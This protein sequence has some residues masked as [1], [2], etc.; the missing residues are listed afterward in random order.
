VK[1]GCD[2]AQVVSHYK[3]KYDIAYFGDRVY[4]MGNDNAIAHEVVD[5]GGT[6]YSVSNPYETMRIMQTLIDQDNQNPH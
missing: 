3:D 6:I 2:K 5:V 4:K 1:K